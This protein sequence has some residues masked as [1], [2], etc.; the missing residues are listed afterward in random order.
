M[1]TK[2]FQKLLNL[3][4]DQ[5]WLERVKNNF[6]PRRKGKYEMYIG[7]IEHLDD[8]IEHNS[9]HIETTCFD[10]QEELSVIH[11]YFEGAAYIIRYHDTKEHISMGIIDGAPFEEIEEIEGT[12]WFWLSEKEMYELKLIP[13]PPVTNL[14][15][16]CTSEERGVWLGSALVNGKE[17][18]QLYQFQPTWFKV[19]DDLIHKYIKEI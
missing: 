18:K 2:T 8:D 12:E 13:Y 3:G 19:K 7:D 1:N 14:N 5:Q 16:K 10:T 11:Y 9:I 15:I 6:H 4:F 17:F